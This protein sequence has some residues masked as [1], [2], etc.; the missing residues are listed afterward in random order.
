MIRMLAAPWLFEVA[1]GAGW[2]EA[3]RFAQAALLRAVVG[4]AAFPMTQAF[5][6]YEK[7]DHLLAWQLT[8][9]VV[10][11]ASLFVGAQIGGVLL[12]VWLYS[13]TSAVILGSAVVL[14]L[15][16]AGVPW[17]RQPGVLIHGLREALR[18]AADESPRAAVHQPDRPGRVDGPGWV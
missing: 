15:S 8:T 4:F 18:G 16:Y 2:D 1:F 10:Q 12:A 13:I 6:V 5:I 7:Q 17:R 11:I 3:G 9:S 14:A